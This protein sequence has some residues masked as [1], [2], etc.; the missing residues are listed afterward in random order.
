M[1]LAEVPFDIT[2]DAGAA[3]V[4]GA[5]SIVYQAQRPCTVPLLAFSQGGSPNRVSL[6]AGDKIAAFYLASADLAAAVARGDL[7]QA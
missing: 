3:I 1:I 4:G 6:K 2:D 7:V 5:F